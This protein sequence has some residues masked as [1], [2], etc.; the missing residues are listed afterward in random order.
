MVKTL[1][2]YGVGKGAESVCSGESLGKVETGF[3][4]KGH[5]ER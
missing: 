1:S 4:N 5:R 2:P 3:P